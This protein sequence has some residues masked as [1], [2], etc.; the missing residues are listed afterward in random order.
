MVESAEY[1]KTPATCQNGA[2][3]YKSC[4]VCGKKGYSFNTFFSET[5]GD[6]KYSVENHDAKYIKEEATYDTPAVFYKSCQCGQPGEET[7]SYGEVLREYTA[8]EKIAYMP[9]SLTMTLYDVE[10]SVY[11]FTYNTKNEPLRPVL[12]IAKEPT[13]FS[14]VAPFNKERS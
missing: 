12:Q 11:G 13:K 10:N 1:F 3:Y 8:E 14:D 4:T 7:F 5:L 6:H 2:E 9:T